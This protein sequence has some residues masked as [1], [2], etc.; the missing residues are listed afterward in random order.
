MEIIRQ[1][2]TLNE[3]Q[4]FLDTYLG[5]ENPYLGEAVLR[6]AEIYEEGGDYKN[7]LE[8]YRLVIESFRTDPTLVERAKERAAALER[9]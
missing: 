7:A 5:T 3:A 1:K 2:F 6:V 9:R 8:T 4:R